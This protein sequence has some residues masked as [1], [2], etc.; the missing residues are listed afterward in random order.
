MTKSSIH[1]PKCLKKDHGVSVKLKEIK[2]VL[3][4]IMDE[5]TDGSLFNQCKI[6]TVGHS[7]GTKGSDFCEELLKSWKAPT[8]R[9]RLPKRLE[10]FVIDKTVVH[11]IQFSE[12]YH[13]GRIAYHRA[14]KKYSYSEVFDRSRVSVPQGHQRNK[15]KAESVR[16]KANH[17]HPSGKTCSSAQK[18]SDSKRQAPLKVRHRGRPRKNEGTAKRKNTQGVGLHG[19]LCSANK[20]T[21]TQPCTNQ[22]ENYDS[23]VNQSSTVKRRGRP[24]KNLEATAS[25]T[26]RKKRKV[27]QSPRENGQSRKRQRSSLAIGL[28]QQLPPKP[29]RRGRPRKIKSVSCNENEIPTD[30]LKL[31][32]EADKVIQSARAGISGPCKPRLNNAVRSTIVSPPMQDTQAELR[33]EN[34]NIIS[35]ASFSRISKTTVG[36]GVGGASDLNNNPVHNGSACLPSQNNQRE[37]RDENNNIFSRVSISGTL[38][39]EMGQRNNGENDPNNNPVHTV[40]QEKKRGEQIRRGRPGSRR[41]A[42]IRDRAKLEQ[43]KHL[44]TTGGDQPRVQRT[45]EDD[46]IISRQSDRLATSGKTL[47]KNPFGKILMSVSP[48]Q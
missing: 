31:M 14:C 27:T 36:Q 4:D 12:W 46:P 45:S 25:D 3:K 6:R 20:Q 22:K 23:A 8:R 18:N 13:N 47:Q 40:R 39:T 44:I 10:G 21:E 33:D 28:Q 34:N 42:R 1:Q 26:S 38:Q 16:K 7:F 48:E 17:P 5:R 30:I 15:Q 2:V 43:Y 37:L 9:H 24:K 35:G 32:Q 11:L 41:S 19:G 29:R